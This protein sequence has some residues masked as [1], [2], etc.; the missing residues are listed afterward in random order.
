[1]TRHM[2]D[3]TITSADGTTLAA[4]RFGRGSPLVIVHGAIG[5]LDTFAL[6]EG[7]LAE[8]HSVWVYSRRGR[9]T[10]A[11]APTT[12]CSAKWKTCWR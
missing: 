8:R 1:M 9:V 12:A 10:A 6:I 5:D 2:P 3:T 4:R 11:M 7:L